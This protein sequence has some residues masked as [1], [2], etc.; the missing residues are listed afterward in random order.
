VGEVA[1]A[2]VLVDVPRRHLANDDLLLDGPR[3]RPR[4]LISQQRHG[5]KR[6][7]A[8]T[9]L[10]TVLQDGRHVPGERD[11]SL[12]HRIGRRLRARRH[13]RRHHYDYDNQYRSHSALLEKLLRFATR[14][15]FYNLVVVRL[16]AYAPG[17]HWHK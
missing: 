5:G 6:V 12:R 17:I 13:E 11:L 10:A 15:F 16:P 2:H 4:I 1:H 3:T 8:M 7:R 14:R 9:H